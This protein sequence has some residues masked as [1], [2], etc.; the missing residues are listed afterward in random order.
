MNRQNVVHLRRL[1]G[2]I[3]VWVGEIV[4]FFE[5]LVSEPEDIQT[6]FV[7]VT[8]LASV[9]HFFIPSN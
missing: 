5:T 8:R 3:V 2:K 6:G 7:A 9:A 1:S 4:G